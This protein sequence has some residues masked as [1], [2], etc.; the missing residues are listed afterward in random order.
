M[1]TYSGAKDANGFW[2]DV[3][4]SEGTLN[5]AANTSRL[6]TYFNLR[7][8]NAGMF[9][10][11]S[12]SVY[13]K[14]V[15]TIDSG[16]A[17]TQYVYQG[18][19][20]QQTMSG[21]SL[22]FGTGMFDIPHDTNGAQSVTIT[23]YCDSV[24]NASYV[25][26]G[27]TAAVTINLT[28]FTRVPTVPGTPTLTRTGSSITATTSGSTFYGSSSLPY[29][30]AYSI[31]AGATWTTISTPHT[32]SVTFD[33]GSTT[34][35]ALVKVLATD[36]EGSSAYSTT[37]SIIGVPVAP[38]AIAATR[39][40]HDVI[41]LA[42]QSEGANPAI[43]YSAQY[44]TN[45]GLTWSTTVAMSGSGTGTY[46]YTNLPP[47][48]TYIFRVYSTNAIGNSA[49][50]TSSGVFVPAGGKRWTGSA[51]ATATTVKRWDGSS[52]VDVSSAK[53][54]NGSAWIELS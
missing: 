12:M 24:T 9:A 50:T 39:V 28:N 8:D 42:G 32:S 48:L 51:W 1:A 49:Y 15:Y 26:V 35:T 41:V 6:T 11:Y 25:P 33:C 31:D 54:W 4:Y 21:T 53:R 27:T 37:A 30:W 34:A 7:H 44:S 18:T 17:V 43:P 47:A 16:A 45:G 29:S 19:T 40:G 23:C 10:G 3:V 36:S 22:T 20:G 46:T 38:T 13:T 5:T 14:Y 2:L 52:W